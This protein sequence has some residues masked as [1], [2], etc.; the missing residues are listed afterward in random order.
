MSC[1][2]DT[3]FLSPKMS[4][5]ST[6]TA[7]EVLAYIKSLVDRICDLFGLEILSTATYFEGKSIF[8]SLGYADD[9]PLFVVGNSANNSYWYRNVIFSLANPAGGPYTT[10]DSSTGNRGQYYVID[11]TNYDNYLKYVKTDN[12]LAFGLLLNS[13]GSTSLSGVINLD[14]I[15]SPINVDGTLQYVCI[16]M[17]SQS[18]YFAYRPVF[19]TASTFVA[20]LTGKETVICAMPV[21]KEALMSLYILNY[22]L[23]RLKRF[24]NKLSAAVSSRIT[25]DGTTYLVCLPGG[26]SYFTILLQID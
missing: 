18:I 13:A 21:E 3:I 6:S 10:Y 17:Y 16:H 14:W 25:I 1:T 7:E 20:G 5:T 11:I 24:T 2:A 9:I 22:N 15:I 19:N 8:Y 12:C 23:Y 26:S 4:F